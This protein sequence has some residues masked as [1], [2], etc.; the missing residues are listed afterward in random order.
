MGPFRYV[1]CDVFTDRPLT[2]NQLAVF[3]DARG[4]DG[5]RMQALAREVNYSESTFVLPPEQGGHVRIRMFTPG[6]EVPFAGHP[7]LGTAFVLAAPLQ[8]DE[9]RLE[10]GAGTVPVRLERDGP[11][12]AFGWMQ[13]PLPSWRPYEQ[14]EE[15][16]AALGVERSELPVEVYDLGPTHAYVALADEAAVAGVQPDLA[17]LARLR[18]GANCFA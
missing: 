6:I 10:T 9:I 18:V 1:V 12:L 16:L 2:G 5:E 4:L 8:L 3:T 15:L 13:Q 17:A 7:T 14:A 11:T